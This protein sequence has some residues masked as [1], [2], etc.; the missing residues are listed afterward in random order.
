MSNITQTDVIR[1][2]GG[3]AGTTTAVANLATVAEPKNQGVAEPLTAGSVYRRSFRNTKKGG[4]LSLHFLVDVVGGATS[5]GT[6]WYS[7]VPD[8]SLA[9][10]SDWVQDTTV[11]TIDLTVLGGKLFNIGNVFAAWAMVKMAPVTT[12]GSYRVF[13]RTEGTSV[14]GL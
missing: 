13:A 1:I 4:H 5:A 8:P 6:V 3:E 10:D 9:N 14:S 11:G 2:Y 12:G 7:N